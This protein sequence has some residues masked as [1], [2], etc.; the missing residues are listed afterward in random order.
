MIYRVYTNKLLTGDIKMSFHKNVKR[1]VE[2]L[3]NK[4]QVKSEV[5]YDW[6]ALKDLIPF[7]LLLISLVMAVS[8]LS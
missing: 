7:T 8:L 2:F 4:N 1:E 5:V 3:K 6:N